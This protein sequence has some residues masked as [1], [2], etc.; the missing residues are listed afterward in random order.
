M[1]RTL[2][3]GGG[4]GG[5]AAATELR[6]LLG[7]GHEITLVDARPRFSMGL[8]K[9]WQLVGHGSIAEGSRERSLLARHGIEFVQ[10]EVVGIDPA[11]RS[12]RSATEEWVGDHLVVALGA[13]SHP[14]LVPGL[15][16]H[17]HDVWSASGVPGA[18]AALARF[19]GGRILVLVAGAPYPCPPAPYE[20]L[21]HLDEHLQARWRPRMPASTR[22]GT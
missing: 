18:A 4:F 14:E 9:L 1:P 16:E 5:I 12:A 7:D 13:E 6:R 19:E 3:L 21:F 22:S 11:A 20:C 8:R 2:I 15:V 17:G 10:Q